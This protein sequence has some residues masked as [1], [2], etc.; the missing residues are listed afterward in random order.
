RPGFVDY[1]LLLCG[2][3]LS[4]LLV[5]WSGLRAVPVQEVG[6]GAETVLRLLPHLLFLPLGIIL[7]WPLFYATQR[8]GGRDTGLSAGEWVWGLAWL[9]AIVLTAW[10]AWRHFGSAADA[11]KIKRGVL[12]GYAVAVASLGLIALVIGLIDLIGR[13][14]QPWTHQLCLALMI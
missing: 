9:G 12:V 8:L 2:C 11:D 5:E 4:L 1:V 6:P 3:A 13:W 14:P 7:L 10:F